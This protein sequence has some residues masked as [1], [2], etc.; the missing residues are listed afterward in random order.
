MDTTV[1][2][3]LPALPHNLDGWSANIL[4][5]YQ[6]LWNAF[7]HALLLLRQEDGD[8][9]R[10]NLSSEGLINDMVPILEQMESEGIPTNFTHGCAHLLGQ[11]VYELRMAAMAAEGVY[12]NCAKTHKIDGVLICSYLQ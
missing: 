9:I 10:L 1:P 2:E 11:L 3:H 12:V 5:A 4:V 6:L 8:P 7:E